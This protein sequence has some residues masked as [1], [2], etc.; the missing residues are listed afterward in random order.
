VL[1]DFVCSTDATACLGASI[2][3][4]TLSTAGSWLLI[5]GTRNWISPDCQQ[6]LVDAGTSMRSVTWP[7]LREFP[8]ANP[9]QRCDTLLDRVS[10]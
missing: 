6:L 9:W 7:M 1:E 8:P 3:V 2:E 4:A 5:D 10:S